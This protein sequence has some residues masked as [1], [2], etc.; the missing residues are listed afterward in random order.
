MKTALILGGH[1][2]IGHHLARDLKNKGFWVRTVDIKEYPYDETFKESVDDYLL[3]D[4][5]DAETC[6]EVFKSP[7][8]QPFDEVYQLAAF[9][10]GAGIVFSGNYD[11]KILNDSLLINLNVAKTATES[12][13]GK[14]FF[15]SS[16]CCYNQFNQ[17]SVDNP[18]TEEN[19]AYPAHPD[20][21]YG[22]E[23]LTSER[24]YLAYHRNQGLNIRIG[25]FHN[26]FGPEGAWNN[27]REK[28]PAALCRKVALAKDEEE[29]I[30]VWGDGNQTR[31]FLYIDECLVTIRK[32]MDSDFIG[33]VNIGSDEMVS[34]NHMVDIIKG[35]AN[36]PKI[37][38]KH[39]PGPLGV[40]GRTS[41][42]RLIREKLNWA[43]DYPLHKGLEKTY[44]WIEQ[45][46]I[47]NK[48][49]YSWTN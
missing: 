30:D 7:L 9:M 20:S 24:I 47:Q 6:I 26:I 35:I 1:G 22:W 34:I 41:D 21:D 28:S 11:S 31:S 36:K 32:F 29:C 38:I 45:Q 25:R 23:K 40:R 15:S 33:P 43:P 19:S 8:H 4:L 18:T 17:E 49:D 13:V 39:I 12:K 27:G 3:K 14:L 2:F 16:A 42:N 10:G 48:P 46:I 5:R 44:A 37:L